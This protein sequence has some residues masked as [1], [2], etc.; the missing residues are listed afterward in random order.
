MMLHR[1]TIALRGGQMKISLNNMY[2][3]RLVNQGTYS[4]SVVLAGKP[5]RE[6]IGYTDLWIRLLV[7]SVRASKNSRYTEVLS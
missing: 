7:F 4:T 6:F 2:T 3:D 1:S 5:N